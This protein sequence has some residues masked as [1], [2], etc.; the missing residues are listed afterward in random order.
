M[1]FETTVRGNNWTHHLKQVDGKMVQGQKC[2]RREV[3]RKGV[4]VI[5]HRPTGRFLIGSSNDVSKDVDKMLMQLEKGKFPNQLMQQLYDRPDNR[6]NK[7]NEFRP[8]MSIIEF[9]LNSDRDIKRTLKEIR[10]TNTTDYCLL[11]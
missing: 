2:G 7:P 8:P 6:P 5:D 11:N 9:P 10:E 1:S 4:W 3:V